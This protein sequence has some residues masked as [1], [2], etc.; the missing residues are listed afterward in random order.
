MLRGYRQFAAAAPEE[1]T[2][3]VV[4]RHAPPAPWIPVDQR[5]KPVVMIGAVHT[6][7]IQTGI[8]A[9]RPVKSLARPVADTVWPTPFLAHQAVLDASNPAGH[10]YYWKSDHL[11]ELNDEAIDLLVEQTAQLSSPDSLI[12]IFQLGGAAARGGERSCFPSRHARFMVNYATHWT[13]AREDDLHRQWTRDAIEALAPYGLGTAYVNFTA[14]DAPMHVE[15]L[16]STT[17]FSRLVTLKNRLDPDNVFRNNHNIRPRHEGPKLTVG[18]TIMDLYSNLVEA[19]QR[20]VALV[21]SIE[22]DSYSSPTPCDRWDVRA[23]LSHALASID[24][25]AAAVDG[26]PGPDMAQVF[27]GADIVGDDP[28]GATQ[29]ITRR[30]QAAWSTVR[31][32]NAEL[33]TFIGVM[34]A[35]QALAIITFSTVVHG[36][37]LAVA[38]G[39]AGELPEH[40]AEAAQQVAAELVPVLRPR[41]L[42]AHD[43]DLAGEA[44]PTQRLVALTGRKP[45]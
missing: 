31:D 43:V 17:E 45:R 41:G 25:F 13:E 26:A 1:V 4:L 18:R 29:R 34:P 7:S 14:D 9:L 8:E 20:L 16:Y 3:I 27:S 6:G 10:R 39:Q 21:S 23:L 15:T 37:D 44:T 12:G 30:S 24:A 28:L 22:A 5:G 38:T 32:L 33:S 42:F 36:W 19:E 2:T 40:L 35:G 11:A